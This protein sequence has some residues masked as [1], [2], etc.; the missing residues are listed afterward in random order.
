MGLTL[1]NPFQ[2]DNPY[3]SGIG[4]MV[5]LILLVVFVFLL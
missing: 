5:G 2:F 1:N 3:S 4:L